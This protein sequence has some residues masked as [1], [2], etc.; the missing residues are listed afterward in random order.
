MRQLFQR[1]FD[2]QQAHNR[3]LAYFDEHETDVDP[4]MI[5]TEQID[6]GSLEARLATEDP[7]SRQHLTDVFFQIISALEYVHSKNLIHRDVRPGTILS[8][9]DPQRGAFLT[10]F[11]ECHF[12]PAASDIIGDDE[13]RAPEIG[14]SKT[15]DAKVDVYSLCTVVRSYPAPVSPWN[16]T[17][18]PEK[19]SPEVQTILGLGL[20]KCPTQR[21]T[22]A[23]ICDVIQNLSGN[24]AG[25]PFQPLRSLRTF[26]LHCD[27]CSFER[28]WD[29]HVQEPDLWRI[30]SFCFDIG[31]SEY[32][33]LVRLDNPAWPSH[34]PFELAKQISPDSLES[35]LSVEDEKFRPR[36][37]DTLVR[38]YTHCFHVYYHTLS[39]MANLTHLLRATGLQLESL[40]FRPS[41]LQ[42][43]YG[44]P[45]FE[46]LYVDA[47][48]F[49]S[50]WEQANTLLEVQRS[51]IGS[52]PDILRDPAS[53]TISCT[54]SSAHHE[55]FISTDYNEHVI[56]FAGWRMILVRRA[57]GSANLNQVQKPESAWQASV[58]FNFV[59]A[60]EAAA[61]CEEQGLEPTAKVLR[62]LG[63]QPPQEFVPIRHQQVPEIVPL[64]ADDVDKPGATKKVAEW[65]EE[66][67]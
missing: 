53:T 6:A 11:S 32:E 21:Y 30:A 10:G 58:P 46:G 18:R 35:C 23:Q 45:K 3:L 48:T 31:R 27:W 24:R 22:S 5:V 2:V 9:H 26:D 63:G 60:Q 29:Y 56:V 55:R 44:A 13:Y 50:L 4:Y 20:V 40:D 33:T 14:S 12:G 66:A 17:W 36:R 61:A 62:Y 43:V 41:C 64:E 47:I 28:K 7:L 1:I 19:L 16:Q 37:P 15:Y 67:I 59:S 52:I 65:L 51:N 54:D 8:H 42:E 38:S 25:P 39:K 57:D 49:E 34:V